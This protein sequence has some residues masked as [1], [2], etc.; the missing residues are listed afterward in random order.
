MII[1]ER[2]NSLPMVGCESWDFL[3]MRNDMCKINKTPVATTQPE[4]NVE[5]PLST[6]EKDKLY[7]QKVDAWLK[8]GADKIIGYESYVL[9]NNCAEFIYYDSSLRQARI[10]TPYCYMQSKSVTVYD[11]DDQ[12]V[13]VTAKYPR[14]EKEEAFEIETTTAYLHPSAGQLPLEFPKPVDNERLHD[15]ADGRSAYESIAYPRILYGRYCE[16]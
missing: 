6:Y 10:E 8:Q 5:P 3:K 1:A 4:Q 2:L 14:D 13:Q 7:E 9:E 15:D 16:K 11:C 12:Y